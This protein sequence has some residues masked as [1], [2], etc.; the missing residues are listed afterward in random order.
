MNEESSIE[1]FLFFA[2]VIVHQESD[3]K[4]SVT[5]KKYGEQLYS[6]VCSPRSPFWSDQPE[7]N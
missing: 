2:S 7:I 1:N 5:L 3:G 6:V 4:V